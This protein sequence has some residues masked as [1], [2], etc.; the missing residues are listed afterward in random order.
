LIKE[1]LAMTQLDRAPQDSNSLPAVEEWLAQLS[2]GQRA[3]L[4][5]N[6][7]SDPLPPEVVEL[8]MTGP[9]SPMQETYEW[10][11]LIVHVAPIVATALQNSAIS[12]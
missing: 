12:D 6:I 3:L 10:D 4:R 2:P 1:V 11:N 5:D 8:L 7:N 9:L